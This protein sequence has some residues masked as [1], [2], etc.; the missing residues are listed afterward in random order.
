MLLVIPSI[1]LHEGHCSQMI[2]GEQGTEHHYQQLSYNPPELCLLWRRENAKTLNLTDFDSI[3][4]ENHQSN[5]EAILYLCRM[6]DIPI[7]VFGNYK[8]IDECIFLLENGVYRIILFELGLSEPE[9]VRE[10]IKKYSASRVSFFI[11]S[12]NGKADFW[13]F[14]Q[15]IFEDDYIGHIKSLGATRL[16]YLDGKRFDNEEE[17]DFGL[18]NKVAKKSGLKITVYGCVSKSEHLWKLQEYEKNGVDSVVIG[19]SLYNNNYPCQ[20][21]WRLIEAELDTKSN[22][23]VSNK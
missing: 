17:P 21:I 3:F 10:L 16:I 22:F 12:V 7:Q 20:K 23:E 13:N 15:T 14:R 18:Y 5:T 1:S 8:S 9:R 4:E 2:R 6:L 19:R 11:N